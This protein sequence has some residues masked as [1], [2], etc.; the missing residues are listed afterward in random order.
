[1]LRA[2]GV[3]L[4]VPRGKAVSRHRVWVH[5]SAGVHTPSHPLG[6]RRAAEVFAANRSR[7][8]RDCFVVV[9]VDGQQQ[10]LVAYRNGRLSGSVFDN[11]F[12]PEPVIV[13]V[14][15]DGLVYALAQKV[16]A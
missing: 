5:D 4:R 6:S 16:S 8:R 11:S 1:V 7:F 3:Q 13:Q 10:K 15:A 9:I 12:D 2:A 14:S